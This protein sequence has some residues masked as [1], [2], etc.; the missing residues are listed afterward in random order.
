MN[1]V[2]ALTVRTIAARGRLAELERRAGKLASGSGGLIGSALKELSAAL[3][4]LHSANEQMRDDLDALMQ[5]RTEAQEA[6]ARL[7]EF[8]NAVRVPC[9]W[10]DEDGAIREANE[11]AAALLNVARQRLPGKPLL[12]FLGE[13]AAFF[14]A[15]LAL[16]HDSHA[17][18]TFDIVVRPREKRPRDARVTARWM[19]HDARWCWFIEPRVASE[20]P[21]G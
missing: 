14:D 18:V 20:D 2:D 9:V 11:A 3:E 5:A 4:D 17:V 15:L 6:A 19:Q 16:K 8:V 7:D 10:T 1:T 12:L 21:S 13:R